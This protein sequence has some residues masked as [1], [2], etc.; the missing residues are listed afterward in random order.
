MVAYYDA[1]ADLARGRVLDAGSGAGVGAR[2][3]A[4][5]GLA[6]TAVDCDPHA[7]AFAR[8]YAPN[9]EHVTADLR[10]FESDLKFDGA[11]LADTLGHVLD[12]EAAL[13]GVAR[14]LEPGALL[15]V[16]ET[17]AHVSQRL[18]PPQRRS[19]SEARLRALLI[20]AGFR[21]EGV[22]SEGIPF[23]A[24]LARAADAAVFQAFSRAYDAAARGDAVGALDGLESARGTGRLEVEV[25][26]LLARSEIYLATGQGD[27]AAESCFRS[28]ELAPADARPLVGLGRIALASGATADALHLALD[29]LA[30]DST[31]AA[32]CALAA[33]AADSLGHPDAFTAWRTASNLAPDDLAVACEFAR[34][35]SR[36]GDHTLALQGIERVER[37]GSPDPAYHVT[38]AWLL[39]AA[40]RTSEAAIEA[41]IAE[42]RSA[43][44]AELDELLAA[45]RRA[46]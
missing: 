11:I 4:L 17:A 3:L 21:V 32:A 28:R 2:R 46:S 24:L 16:A 15:L 20:R 13:M 25:E 42:A 33:V 40:N 22:L 34:G 12:P 14:V 29:A 38:R 23:V 6:V 18:T 26:I 19:F 37:Y 44:R 36:R 39:L 43:D 10:D 41:R 7:I 45:I 27:L 9:V 1:F 8:R 5:R 35:A 30:R 31:E